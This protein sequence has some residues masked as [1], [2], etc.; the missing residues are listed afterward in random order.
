MGIRVINETLKTI[1]VAINSW[2][3][4]GNTSTFSIS[5]NGDESWSRSDKRGFVMHVQNLDDKNGAWYVGHNSVIK[6]QKG[7]KYE[8]QGVAKKI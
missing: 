4:S 8:A 5:P 1:K 6:F 7:G 3:E 2:G